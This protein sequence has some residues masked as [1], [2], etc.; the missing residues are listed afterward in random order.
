[1]KILSERIKTWNWSF[2]IM[3]GRWEAIISTLSVWEMTTKKHKGKTISQC[4]IYTPKKKNHCSNFI[5]L[6]KIV[7]VA[8]RWSLCKSMCKEEPNWLIF[9]F[10]RNLYILTIV[11]SSSTTKKLFVEFNKMHT[12]SS[13]FYTSNIDQQKVL[14]AQSHSP[15][16]LP[17]FES[18]VF[19]QI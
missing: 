11:Q 16:P 8:T 17:A 19:F 10:L 1:M 15:A 9:S 13:N 4:H 5:S 12:L 18:G 3:F 7:S 14:P 2:A 6:T